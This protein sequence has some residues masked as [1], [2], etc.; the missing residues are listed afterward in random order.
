MNIQISNEKKVK[1]NPSMIG[2]FFEDINYAA[3]G[4]LYAEMIENRSFSFVKAMGDFGDY[5]TE[6]A[7]LY[8]WSFEGFNDNQV[9]VVSGSPLSESNNNYLRLICEK[10]GNSVFNK[11]YEG[12]C[13]KKDE[14]YNVLIWARTVSF[15]G[16]FIV[17]AVKDGNSFGTQRISSIEFC[18]E[19]YNFW[20]LYSFSFKAID[21]VRGAKFNLS[22]EGTGVIEIAYVSLIPESAVYGIFRKD[23][24]D[25]LKELKPGFIRFPGG[26]IVEG[27]TLSS[28]YNF[29]ETLK[30]TWDRKTNWNRWAVHGNNKDNNYESRY[31]WYNQTYGMGFYEFFLLCES[32]K[33]KPLPV[34]NVG[35]ACQYQS[36]EM[37]A[38]DSAEF[39]EF[40][41]DAL[42]LIEFANG[43]PNSKWG[44]VRAKM[45]HLEPFN[46]ECIGIGNEQWQTET[47]DF[48]ERY[49]AFEKT[50]HE[51]YPDIKLIGSAGPDITSERYTAAWNFYRAN[52][53]KKNF[54]FALDEHYYVKPEYL[55]EHNDFYDNYD[56]DI[57]VF[58]GEYAAHPACDMNRPDANTLWGALSEAAFLT[59]V[60]RNADVVVLA[61]YAPLFARLNYAQWSPD[62]IWFDDEKAYGSPSYYVQK[63]YANNMGD[64]TLKLYGLDEAV[65]EGVYYSLSFD[66][67]AKE[68]ILKIINSNE[69]EIPINL[70][71]DVKMKKEVRAITLTGSEKNSCNSVNNTKNVAEIS[72]VSDIDNLVLKPL[73]FNVFRF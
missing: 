41:Q 2:L 55:F 14:L 22:F 7:P 29:K 50:I 47:A 49:C 13:L 3:D 68:Y 43:S 6:P 39:K 44:S 40:L 24:Y 51:V 15:E 10:K 18:D 12:L 53:N 58:S 21:D 31:A 54:A 37:V 19:K 17:N 34:L 33:A 35:F 64:Y 45:G 20:K 1:I 46:L 30:P 16:D 72:Y 27:N 52:K 42:D 9:K 28:R 73:S 63:M 56:R 4:G 66:S 26:C 59:G 60:E 71:G 69:F 23:L 5:F 70:C 8:A 25:L 65:K 48:F 61:S 38:I 11:G 62:M 67:K 57:K 32:I 36:K